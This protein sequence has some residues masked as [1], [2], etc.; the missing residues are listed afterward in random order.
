MW[1]R[2]DLDF[3]FVP[4]A[5][6]DCHLDASGLQRCGFSPHAE[7]PAGLAIA[8]ARA[9]R[10]SLA[11]DLFCR[12]ELPKLES[13]LYND[14]LSAAPWKVDVVIPYK[15]KSHIN[16]LELASLGVLHRPAAL[17]S[18]GSTLRLQRVPR[19][20]AGLALWPCSPAEFWALPC[21]G[22]SR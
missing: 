3:V 2:G 7:I 5:V 11:S 15:G 1:A 8:L 10:A 17:E 12:K 13:V 6:L 22:Q 21:H 19:L 20:R 18:P 16:V 14:V 4:L 9:F